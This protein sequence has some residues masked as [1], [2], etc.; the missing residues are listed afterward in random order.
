MWELDRKCQFGFGWSDRLLQVLSLFQIAVRLTRRNGA[1]LCQAL[2]SI[3]KL[4]DLSKQ[5]PCT[6]E[7]FGLLGFARAWYLS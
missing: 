7:A 4:I 2:D 6:I 3:G 5:Y 1:V